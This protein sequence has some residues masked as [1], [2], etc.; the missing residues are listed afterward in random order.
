MDIPTSTYRL[1]FNPEFGFQNAAR[2]V[3]YLA[4]LGISHIYASPIF[5][6]K[7]GSPHGYDGVDPNQLNEELGS[8]DDFRVLHRKLARNKIGW[9]QDIVPNHMAFDYANRMLMDVLQNG[10]SSKYY[11]FFD[12]EWDQPQ[13]TG[14]KRLM[15]P[16]LG[17]RFDRCLK[18]GEF[19]LSFDGIG[20]AVNYYQ[21]K[22]SLQME[23]YAELLKSI[24]AKLRIK[25]GDD[26]LDYATLADVIERLNKL[27]LSKSAEA[28][29]AEAEKIRSNLRD[30]Y[31]GNAVIRRCFEEVLRVYNA[32]GKKGKRRDDLGKLL[33]EQ[34]FRLCY[35]KIANEQ[36]NYRRFFDINELICLRQENPEVFDTTHRL[37]KALVDDGYVNGVRIDHVDG[38]ADPA[39]YLRRLRSHLGDIFILVEKILQPN[40][41]ER[42]GIS[43]GR[44]PALTKWR[45]AASGRFL[46]INWAAI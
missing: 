34:I 3:P 7:K 1:Q 13:K 39:K 46:K 20:F 2:I 5:K 23:S 29:R 32:G 9:L 21:L 15:A 31:D 22:L 40:L 27:S 8:R 37:V 17:C 11:T 14:Q 25:L 19:K 16:F 30:L 24:G 43:A 36:I 28:R 38:L 18:N 12:I 35:W 41:K 26:H 33:S 44:R 6:A 42:I 45:T 4:D 10:S